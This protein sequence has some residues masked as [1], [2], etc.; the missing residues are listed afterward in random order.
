MKI[1]WE[2]D[3]RK[4][5]E[6][7]TARYSSNGKTGLPHLEALHCL[8]VKETR[9]TYIHVKPS[10]RII[11]LPH[12][13]FTK[14]NSNSHTSY[15]TR[16]R[17]TTNP[18]HFTC[19]NKRYTISKLKSCIDKYWHPTSFVY[20]ILF[21]LQMYLQKLLMLLYQVEMLLYQVEMLQMCCWCF[22]TR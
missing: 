9:H 20:K 17:V 15:F 12:Q 10:Q 16:L 21:C 4:I 1:I 14:N 2:M 18:R 3:E 13:P 6:H 19:N 5:T 11:S 22:Y 7:T 8:T